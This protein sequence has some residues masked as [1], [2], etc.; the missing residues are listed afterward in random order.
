MAHERRTRSRKRLVR[1]P[2]R[3][4]LAAL[5]ALCAGTPLALGG[6]PRL[7]M[8]I[9][10]TG[11]MVLGAA[12]LLVSS[13]G[14]SS[15]TPAVGWALGLLVVVTLIQLVPLPTALLRLLAPSTL[16]AL[17]VSH[18]LS[19]RWHPLSA[20]PGNTAIALLIAATAAAVYLAATRLGSDERTR[21]AILWVLMGVGALIAL[22]GI[23]GVVIAPHRNLLFYQP[24]GARIISGLIAT[25]FVNPNNSAG[26]LLL[27]IFSA[28]AV[29][30]RSRG[31]FRLLAI[32]AATLCATGIVLSLSRAGV[33]TLFFG[34]LALPLLLRPVAPRERHRMIIALALALPLL[35]IGLFTVLF[36]YVLQS[37]SAH[38][39]GFDK[40]QI[41]EAAWHA[42]LQQP[43][44]GYGRG[45]TMTA[46]PR[47]L[48]STTSGAKTIGFI[49][50]GP[51]QLFAEIGVAPSLAI[52]ALIAL[53]LWTWLR[54]DSTTT[55]L[56]G[57]ALA[58]LMLQNFF[59]YSLELLG[60][61][62]PAACLAGVT[63]RPKRRD[64]KSSRPRRLR[65]SAT[66]ALSS[67]LL[68]VLLTI[69]VGWPVQSSLSDGQRLANL[70]T[71]RDPTLLK[72]LAR[73]RQHHPLD[74]YNHYL[75]AILKARKGDR[76]AAMRAL[77]RA[78][79]LNP[80]GPNLHLL[81][82]DLLASA[83]QR[84]QALLELKAAAR[85]GADLRQ[86]FTRG[87]RLARGGREWTEL[88][89]YSAAA[90]HRAAVGFLHKGRH[91]LAREIAEA[92]TKRWPTHLHLAVVACTTNSKAGRHN[93]ALTRA[94]ALL[95]AFPNSWIALRTLAHTARL[96]KRPKAALPRLIARSS[97]H[98]SLCSFHLELALTALA[99]GDYKRAVE[100]SQT[101][102][103]CATKDTLRR[104]AHLVLARAYRAL[105]RK[106][107]A[108]IEMLAARRLGYKKPTEVVANPTPSVAKRPA[109]LR[110]PI[111][112]GGRR[113]LFIDRHL[114]AR[115][116]GDTR[117][118]VH[119]P[120]A[121]EVV[122]RTNRPWEGNTSAYFSVLHDGRLYR[123]YYRGSGHILKTSRPLSYYRSRPFPPLAP[124]HPEYACYAESVDGVRWRRP[125]VG[126]FAFRGDKRN[127][128]V[129]MGRGA[130]NFT[131]FIDTRLGP[132]SNQRFKALIRRQGRRGL[133]MA[134]SSD[135]RR[136][137]WLD[138]KPRILRGSFDSQNVAFW[139]RSAKLYREYHRAYSNRVRAIMTTTSRDGQRWEAPQELS[140]SRDAKGPAIF[141]SR[142]P[143]RPADDR[144]Q[145]YTN[146]ITPYFRA[147][148][149]LL[150]LPS[151][152]LPKQN[153]RTI[154]RLISSRDGHHFTLWSAMLIP[155]RGKRSGNRANFAALG[156]VPS[157]DPREVAIYATEG[158]VLESAV[159]LRRFTFRA[160]GFVSLRARK[161]SALTRE[162]TYTG[163]KLELNYRCLKPRG[164]VVV[165]I[166]GAK[167]DVLRSQKL[168]GD[169]IVGDVRFRKSLAGGAGAPIRLRFVLRDAEIF[170]FRFIH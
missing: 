117:F 14:L 6:A 21:F 136:W 141:L 98:S 70:A 56:C 5:C 109:R 52:M 18:G 123:L 91:Q 27:S 42:G 93:T 29:A 104:Q 71:A 139:Q 142:E 51:L 125:N 161:G 22:M 33:A 99:A 150:G 11:A 157:N 40:L 26:F 62:L 170:A 105:G 48:P 155:P 126:I 39:G 162:L 30:L 169:K 100:A 1:L 133:F 72:E 44:L 36:K 68:L 159:T 147:P 8:L 156:I 96:A 55:R 77:N 166:I 135:G 94:T 78:I 102:R 16:E 130:H 15:S 118:Q 58:M 119:R 164:S 85:S 12:T 25:S 114:I 110:G 63:A 17:G 41:W 7:A 86:V 89:S 143:G 107:R 73:A 13:R 75:E 65:H 120:K 116:G 154:P 146:A 83:G 113:E 115:L 90:T 2:R 4:L 80:W 46:L 112:I 145:L 95:Q 151:E 82:S 74:D 121:R 134:V 144:Q 149:I 64:S 87:Q 67:L 168:R 20:D 88:L 92:G 160:D 66:T 53:A 34:C 76:G 137:R 59:D 108:E 38:L 103:S 111:A 79:Y 132:A 28:L 23:L 57:L 127:N 106:H 81:G 124:R 3:L 10:A 97:Q 129:W 19:P 50:N 140:Y 128:I 43:L 47:Y 60:V 24:Q 37:F 152:V 49:E 9:A 69:L 32:T 84:R 163:S 31:R 45:A 131:P 148:H 153:T 35:V 167:G 101:L 61:A 122:L 165:E 158:Y 54:S 138:D